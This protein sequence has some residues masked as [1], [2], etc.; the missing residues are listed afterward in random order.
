MAALCTTPTEGSSPRNI[1]LRMMDAIAAEQMRYAHRAISWSAAAREQQQGD[2]AVERDR[3]L[4][5]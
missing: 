2:P 3:P 4:Q 5:H 1:L